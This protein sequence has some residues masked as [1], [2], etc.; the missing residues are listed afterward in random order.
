MANFKY[1]TSDL[2]EKFRAVHGDKYDYSEYVYNGMWAKSVF[3]C[4]E[5]GRFEQTSLMHLKTCGCKKCTFERKR[6]ARAK[7]FSSF[8]AKARALH[9]DKYSYL[10]F[11]YLGSM[12]KWD[13]W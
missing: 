8:V 2:I 11:I 10:N 5:H 12:V 1:T 13:L 9:G 4:P 7:H 6:R 3:I